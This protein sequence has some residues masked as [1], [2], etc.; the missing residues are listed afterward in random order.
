MAATTSN[1]M[2]GRA[3]RVRE[4][5]MTQARR[6]SRRI[7]EGL[8]NAMGMG[9]GHDQDVKPLAAA[10]LSGVVLILVMGLLAAGLA[11]AQERMLRDD[12]PQRYTVVRGDTL[13]DISGRFL[14]HPWQW[15]QVWRVN[16]QIANPH[17][18]Y[19]GDVIV[20]RDCDG[21]P[22]LGL[23]RGQNVVRLSPEI[24]RIPRREAIPPLPLEVVENQ[25]K[26]YSYQNVVKAYQHMD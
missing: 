8:G 16:P 2:P 6:Q 25:T 5:E 19:P 20:I 10:R 18:I 3:P 1:Q 14:N 21:R 9:R 22:C 4:Q 12:A 15:P 7:L 17:L 23:E 11:H 13:W 26:S 24:K